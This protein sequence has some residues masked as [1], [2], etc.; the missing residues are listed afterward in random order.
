MT[1]EMDVT[2]ETAV[3]LVHADHAW[4]QSSGC[5]FNNLTF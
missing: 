5:K 2:V 1:L 3:T 4:C